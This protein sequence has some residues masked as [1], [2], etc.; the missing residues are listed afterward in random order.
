MAGPVQPIPAT[1]EAVTTEF[2]SLLRNI[3][4]DLHDPFVLWQVG[5]LLACLLGGWLI[6]RLVRQRTG[7]GAA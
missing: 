7:A 1:A 5:A 2:A 4:D 3:W 6:Q